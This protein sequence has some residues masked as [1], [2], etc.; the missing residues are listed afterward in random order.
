MS[1]FENIGKSDE[2]YTPKYIFDAFG[3]EFDLDV[4]APKDISKLHVPAKLFIH[5]NALNKAWY[6]FVWMNPPFGGRNAI[7]PWLDRIHKHGNGIAL[8][9]DR[10]SADWW[11]KAASECDCLMFVSKKIKFIKPDGTSAGSPSSGTTFFAYGEQAKQVLLNAQKNKLGT[12]YY[13]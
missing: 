3:C 11:Q 1:H 9:P 2:W 8:A 10:T 12:I 6:G 7:G 5:A 13:K 4:A